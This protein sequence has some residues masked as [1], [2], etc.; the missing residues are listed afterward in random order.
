M[1][2]QSEGLGAGLDQAFLALM[3]SLTVL[4]SSVHRSSVP[5]LVSV[6]HWSSVHWFQKP[7]DVLAQKVDL[8][9]VLGK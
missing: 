9:Q 2:A 1:L 6:V 5:S 7:S 3:S 4:V 8:G